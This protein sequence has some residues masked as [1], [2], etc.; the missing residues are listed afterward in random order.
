MIVFIVRFILAMFRLRS[1]V[2]EVLIEMDPMDRYIVYKGQRFL[3][4]DRL[5]TREI[6]GF[7]RC[8]ECDGDGWDADWGGVFDCSNCGGSGSLSGHWVRSPHF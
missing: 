2:S 3:K 6:N 8:K 1:I 5:N 7:V 4:G